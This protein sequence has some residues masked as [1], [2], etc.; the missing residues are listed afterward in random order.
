EPRHTYTANGTYTVTL[1]ASNDCGQKSK[2]IQITITTVGSDQAVSGSIKLY[3]NPND[4]NFVLEA[5]GAEQESYDLLVYNF[6]GQMIE[7]RNIKISEPEHKEYFRM[8]HLAKG[9]YIFEI[10]KGEKQTRIKFVIQ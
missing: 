10:R 2:T 5:F 9:I 7:K 8:S 4:G 6:M 3:P 1:F